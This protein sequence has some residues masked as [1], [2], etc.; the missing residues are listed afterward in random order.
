M[1]NQPTV[2]DR[3]TA[4]SQVLAV[5]RQEYAERFPA[6]L[7]RQLDELAEKME[8]TT[9]EEWLPV[10]GQQLEELGLALVEQWENDDTINLYI[11]ELSSVKKIMEQIECEGW[12]AIVHKQDEHISEE[13][14]PALAEVLE[15]LRREYSVQFPELASNK[16]DQV[17]NALTHDAVKYWISGDDELAALGQELEAMGLALVE[18]FE[19]DDSKLYIFQQTSLDELLAEI[20][21]ESADAFV[22]RQEECPPG[23]AAYLPSPP[24]TALFPAS[25]YHD[26]HILLSLGDGWVVGHS[27]SEPGNALFDL[28]KWPEIREFRD[29]N[30]DLGR[31]HAKRA[32]GLCAWVRSVN[33]L[34]ENSQGIYEELY[35]EEICYTTGPLHDCRIIYTLPLRAPQSMSQQSLPDYALAFVGND[36][37]VTD[38][39]GISIY[40]QAETSGLPLVLERLLELPHSGFSSTSP[41]IIQTESGRTFALYQRQLFEWSKD[42]LWRMPFP[43]VDENDPQDIYALT[44]QGDAIIWIQAGMLCIGDTETEDI[45]TYTLTGMPYHDALQLERVHH[46]W[47][48]LRHASGQ[49]PATD[50]AQLWH[51]GSDRVLRI[52][53]GHLALEHGLD[54]W[55]ELPDESILVSSYRQCVNIGRFDDLIQRLESA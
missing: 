24:A 47:L 13:D 14:L 50:I 52:R 17:V 40:R 27:Q 51:L 22:L 39:E 21:A 34:P 7:S 41:S 55:I 35:H 31:L 3:K 48:L 18:R 9:S 32:D 15:T 20:D 29:S 25:A 23:A 4:F 45:T 36:L 8:K 28:S 49:H 33:T 19:D 10:M 30:T 42:A 1:Q 5:M 26:L 38:S 46:D 6:I 16:L 12:Q 2:S 37:L 54:H 43:V 11:V 44:A 53:H